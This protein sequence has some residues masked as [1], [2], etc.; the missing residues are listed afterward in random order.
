MVRVEEAWHF[1]TEPN[2][3]LWFSFRICT[4]IGDQ[5]ASL[6]RKQISST[7]FGSL[8][9]MKNKSAQSAGI[10]LVFIY[11]VVDKFIKN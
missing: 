8:K 11:L 2:G 5:M 9:N 3:L 7:T 10:K 4:K 6:K 1:L